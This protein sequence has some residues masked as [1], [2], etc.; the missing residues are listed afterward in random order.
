MNILFDIQFDNGRYLE[1]FRY[2]E[3]EARMPTAAVRP[4]L[5]HG[6]GKTVKML[7]GKTPGYDGTRDALGRIDA[8]YA[9]NSQELQSSRGLGRIY[10]YLVTSLHDDKKYYIGTDDLSKLPA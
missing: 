6:I 1:N 2:Q 4:P 7:A 8:H 5:L 9:R 3:G 10:E